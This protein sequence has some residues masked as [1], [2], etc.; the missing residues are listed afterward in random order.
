MQQGLKSD[1]T[2]KSKSSEGIKKVSSV[3]VEVSKEEAGASGHVDEE[4]E[5]DTE[6][7]EVTVSS[8]CANLSGS[9]SSLSYSSFSPSPHPPFSPPP[10]PPLSFLSPLSLS[11]MKD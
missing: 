1:G 9:L 8:T 5:T 3:Q 6:D 11:L 2:N 10:P 4:R 7:D